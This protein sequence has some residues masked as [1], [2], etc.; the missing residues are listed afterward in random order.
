MKVF[1]KRQIQNIL[2]RVPGGERVN[3]WMQMNITKGLPVSDDILASKI[4]AGKIHLENYLKYNKENN[5]NISGLSSFEFGAGYDLI[6][7]YVFSFM[8]LSNIYCVDIKNKA[9]AYLLNDALKRLPAMLS[10]HEVKKTG[11]YEI[12]HKNLISDLKKNYNIHYM[13]PMDAGNTN[14]R[15]ESIDLVVSNATLEHIPK[16][17]IK[18]ILKESYRILKPG[19]ILSHAIDYKDHWAYIDSNLSYY[20]FLKYSDQIW[21]YKNPSLNYQNRL[22]HRDYIDLFKSAGFQIKFANPDNPTEK[23]KFTLRNLKIN[24][25][26]RSNYTFDELSVLGC[27]F[28]LT[29]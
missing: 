20:N 16:D 25:Y 27:F 10:Y 5:K 6:V 26:F 14:L 9:S 21:K 12:T 28:V 8:K 1:I 22:R 23:D 13:A 17:S 7:P 18:A 19:G 15:D 11:L 24:D 29:K 2:S 4:E 3:L